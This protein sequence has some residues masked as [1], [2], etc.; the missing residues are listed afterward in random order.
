MKWTLSGLLP[1]ALTPVLSASPVFE[2]MYPKVKQ[3][4]AS[5]LGTQCG[6]PFY[7][8]PEWKNGNFGTLEFPNLSADINLRLPGSTDSSRISCLFTVRF[9]GRLFQYRLAAF[10][11]DIGHDI[12]RAHTVSYEVGAFTLNGPISTASFVLSGKNYRTMEAHFTPDPEGRDW[13]ACGEELRYV[14]Y[15]IRA[16]GPRLGASE[17]MTARPTMHFEF[18]PC[19]LQR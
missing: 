15:D 2:S 10:S 7:V 6:D 12:D 4:D 18:R 1:L 8:K 19:L 14:K 5:M 11:M 17:I 16:R 9:T 13:S 3:V